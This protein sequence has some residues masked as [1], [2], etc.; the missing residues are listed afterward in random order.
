MDVMLYGY[1]I[2]EL[3]RYFLKKFTNK[4]DTTLATI[5]VLESVIKAV[6]HTGIEIYLDGGVRRGSDVFKALALGAK[7]FIIYNL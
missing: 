7:F 5:D 2:M 6:K 4:I 3:G 1:Q